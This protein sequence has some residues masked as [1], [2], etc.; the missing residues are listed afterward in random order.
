MNRK[1]EKL[2]SNKW[3]RGE[4]EIIEEDDEKNGNVSSV[5]RWKRE[6]TKKRK[7]IKMKA[8]NKSNT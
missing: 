2:K 6:K 5:M 4:E 7:K 1:E 3:K 8:R